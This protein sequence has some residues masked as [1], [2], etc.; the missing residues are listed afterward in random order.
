MDAG[1]TLPA[2]QQASEAFYS[3]LADVL[4]GDPRSMLDLWSHSDD[5]TYMG[6]MDGT[7]TVG[8]GPI[9]QAWLDQADARIGGQVAT[10][11]LHYVVGSDLGIVVNYEVGSGHVGVEG[12]KR[13]RATSSYRLEN[14]QVKMI[15]HHTDRF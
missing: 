9:R 1:L 11:G 12:E 5:V 10:E 15:G 14:G 2:L 8:W 3:A 6:P 7:V 13:I 4:A